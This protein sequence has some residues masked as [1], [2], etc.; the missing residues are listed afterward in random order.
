MS[1]AETRAKARSKLAN[2]KQRSIQ[3]MLEL[4]YGKLPEFV[5]DEAELRELWSSPDTRRKLLKGLEEMGFGDVLAHG[6]YA[7]QPIPREARLGQ[8]TISSMPRCRSAR[9]SPR[10]SG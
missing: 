8:G 4:P 10:T 7:L 6:A 9:R 2:G 3:H 5:K 1:E